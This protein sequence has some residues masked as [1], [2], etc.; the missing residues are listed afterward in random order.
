MKYGDEVI[1]TD[2]TRI[3]TTPETVSCELYNAGPPMPE[4]LSLSMTEGDSGI[5]VET[6]DHEYVNATCTWS[7][8][9]VPINV[10]DLTDTVSESG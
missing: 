9:V 7:F 6:T 10:D 2:T 5:G 4:S 3:H 1:T 8:P